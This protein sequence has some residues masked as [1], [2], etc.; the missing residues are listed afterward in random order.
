MSVKLID[1][2][3]FYGY[4]VRRTVASKLYQEYFSLMSQGNSAGS[5]RMTATKAKIVLGKATKRDEE[6]IA[7]RDKAKKATKTSRCFHDD[8]SVKGISLNYKTEASGNITPIY[9]IGCQSEVEG[10]VICTSFSIKAHGLVK[11]WKMA[12]DCFCHHK[13]ISTRT[14]AYKQ[15]IAARIPLDANKMKAKKKPRKQVKRKPKRTKYEYE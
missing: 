14:K 9:Q 5:K 8:G 6:L 12:V 11:S 15:I 1:N 4:R 2:E 13:Q 10:K 7:L 3:A